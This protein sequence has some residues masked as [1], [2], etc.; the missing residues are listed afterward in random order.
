VELT[1]VM[2]AN[3]IRRYE[4]LVRGVPAPGAAGKSRTVMSAVGVSVSNAR[5]SVSS[6]YMPGPHNGSVSSK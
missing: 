4:P 5:D 3:M 6:K 2:E 1:D